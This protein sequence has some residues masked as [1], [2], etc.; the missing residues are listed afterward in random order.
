MDDEMQEKISS[1]LIQGE[2]KNALPD[3]DSH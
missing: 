2:K 3:T 1:E